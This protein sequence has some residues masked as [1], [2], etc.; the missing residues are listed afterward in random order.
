MLKQIRMEALLDSQVN[1]IDKLRKYKVGAL[2]MEPGTGKTMA[3]YRL[4]ESVPDVDYYLWLTPF[5]TKANLAVEL[6]KCNGNLVIDIVGIESLS[7]SDRIYLELIDK[8]QRAARPFIILDESLKIK[9]WTA[10][11]TKRIV[12]LGSMAGYKLILNGTPLS[13][14]L[15]DLWAQMEFLS[16][17]ILRMGLSEYKNTFCEYVTIKKHLGH[18]HLVKE[19][20]T[21]YHNVDY[22]YNLI[23]PFVFESNL[24]ISSRKLYIDLAW[25]LSSG[26]KEEYEQMKA[27]YLDDKHMEFRNN[28]IFL[29]ITSKLQH[30]YS[31]SPDKLGIVDELMKRIDHRSVL[32]MARFIST[33]DHLRKLYPDITVLSWQKHAYGLNLQ[34]YS[35]IIFFDKVWDY[36]LR[37]QAEHRVYRTGQNQDC[38]FYDLTGNVGLE[39]MM[40]QNITR[41]GLLLKYFKKRSVEELR[42]ML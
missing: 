31:L 33:Q 20:I 29:E 24:E 17:K 40:N 6:D 35:R 37:D 28:N 5:Q 36:A 3:A 21:G 30:F 22:L 1:A 8:L 12:R 41:K 18:R 42:K 34:N 4:A 19:F 25:S 15:L 10:I 2:F 16:P 9:N 13:R 7:N 39:D 32:I 38:T 14:N 11:R 23:E 27:K 26:E